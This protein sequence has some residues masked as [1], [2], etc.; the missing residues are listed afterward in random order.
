V[1]NIQPL[2]PAC[3]VMLV[4]YERHCKANWLRICH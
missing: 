2:L 1:R 4:Q 3:E